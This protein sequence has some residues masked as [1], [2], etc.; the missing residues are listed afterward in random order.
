MRRF[1]LFYRF[2]DS[3][4]KQFDVVEERS[5]SFFDW[6]EIVPICQSQDLLSTGQRFQVKLQSSETVI[7]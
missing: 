5:D 2:A 7:R 3:H 4:F 6:P 1:D